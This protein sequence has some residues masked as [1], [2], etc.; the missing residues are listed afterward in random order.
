MQGWIAPSILI[1]L[2]WQTPEPAAQP[3]S[4]AMTPPA[5]ELR[6]SPMLPS[7]DDR[8]VTPVDEPPVDPGAIP[9]A[10]HRVTTWP[11]VWG[12]FEANIYFGGNR[13]APNGEPYAPLFCVDSDLNLGI[14]PHKQLYI[15]AI[16]DFWGERANGQ[17]TNP[18][19]G[20]LDFSKREFDLVGGI[21]WNYYGALELRGIFYSF[22][23][24]NRG[25]S[26]TVPYGFNDGVGVENR[27]YLPSPDIY[28]IS[29][30]SFLS[31]GYLPSK[32][33]IGA[34]GV[35]FSPGFFARAF[36]TYDVP[37]IRSYLF[38]DGQMTAQD[39]MDP[40]LFTVDS[41]LGC[42]PFVALP[43]LE[44]R[45]GGTDIYDRIAGHNRGM[46]YGAI[47]LIY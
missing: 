43:N 41:G 31:V 16:T 46:G 23:N 15:F 28:D 34:N 6:T 10:L 35:P 18:H 12:T 14:L 45:L 33:L 37:G 39:A 40:R 5:R 47:R 13:M 11:E 26:L 44:F 30:L 42:R 4:G 8:L 27:L 17:D 2:A 9:L 29:R 21:A 20:I 3:E 19:Q 25:N 24:L 7:E 32:T 36:L 22:N 38:F 1:F